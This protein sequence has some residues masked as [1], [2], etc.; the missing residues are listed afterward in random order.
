MTAYFK[1]EYIAEANA[2]FR[3]SLIFYFICVFLYLVYSSIFFV[4]F[5][6][7]P[8]ADESVKTI[9]G[10]LY[11]V[12]VLFVIFSF[13]YL[14][15]KVKRTRAYKKLCQNIQVG[16]K[17]KNLAK[18]L[19]YDHYVSEK[20]GVEMKSLIFIEWNKYKKED[21]E[22]KVYVF[23]D[24]ELPKLEK[25]QTVSFITQGNVLYEYEIVN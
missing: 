19:D 23:C 11:P 14:G 7:L 8:Y 12:S 9:K 4:W 21:Y 16:L 22:R 3:K 24:K 18:F 15:I 1:K 13:I 20:D 10:C 6:R 17:E 5:L 2:Q 25:G